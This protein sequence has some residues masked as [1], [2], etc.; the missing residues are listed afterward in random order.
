MKGHKRTCMYSA[1][2]NGPKRRGT[3]FNRVNNSN[4][5]SADG[6]SMRHGE[7]TNIPIVRDNSD[8]VCSSGNVEEE[9]YSISGDRSCNTTDSGN[10]IEPDTQQLKH[11]TIT[12]AEKI[13]SFI[14]SIGPKHGSRLLSLLCDNIFGIKM[15]RTEMFTLKL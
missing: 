4:C 6:V 10:C 3:K 15:L 12:M 1:T 2:H 9:E 5:F 11:D 13:L 7:G 8:G 14:E